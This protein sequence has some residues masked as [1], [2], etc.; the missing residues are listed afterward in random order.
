MA[1]AKQIAQDLLISLADDCTLEE[2]SYR[3]YLRA[4][5]DEGLEDLDSG[6]VVPHEQVIRE[7][8]ECLERK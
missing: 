8:R 7:A 3:L 2:I 1:T 6:R 4:K 5:V